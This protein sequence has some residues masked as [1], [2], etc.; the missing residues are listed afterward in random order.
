M[1]LDHSVLMEL[2]TGFTESESRF[3]FVIRMHY[4][5]ESETRFSV[6]TNP[7]SIIEYTLRAIVKGATSLSSGV[8]W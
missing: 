8:C 3:G 4:F 5:T 2:Q 1:T 7:D 6:N